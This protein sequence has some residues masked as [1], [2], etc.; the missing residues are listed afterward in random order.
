VYFYIRTS[1][2]I[3]FRNIVNYHAWPSYNISW[4]I[5][6]VKLS[7]NPY[8]RVRKYCGCKKLISIFWRIYT[9][10][11]LLNRKTWFLECHIFIYAHALR[12]CL[13]IWTEIKQIQYVTVYLSYRWPMNTNVLAKKKV[14]AVY[15]S[16][17]AQNCDLKKLFRRIWLHVYL[18][19]R[20]DHICT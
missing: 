10:S 8:T 13:I 20:G 19:F 11:S 16:P 6:S 3:T 1:L 9:F 17:E 12:Q 14:G 15:S 18:I 2:Q 5:K 7:R 4:S